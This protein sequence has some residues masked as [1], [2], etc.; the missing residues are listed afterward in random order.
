M[1]QKFLVFDYVGVERKLYKCQFG[2]LKFNRMKLERFD[3]YR[4][5]FSVIEEHRTY[6]L[7]EYVLLEV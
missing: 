6:R 5:S 2:Q 1:C 7:H 3:P 4:P